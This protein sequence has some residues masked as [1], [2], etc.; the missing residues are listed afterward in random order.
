MKLKKNVEIS[1]GTQNLRVSIWDVQVAES[2]P[3]EEARIDPLIEELTKHHKMHNHTY[4]EIVL[5]VKGEANIVS[6]NDGISVKAPFLAF[7]PSGVPHV[8]INSYEHG[9]KRYLVNCFDDFFEKAGLSETEYTMLANENR[10][11]AIKLKEK[12]ADIFEAI[13][14]L[15]MKF[16]EDDA[17]LKEEMTAM[18]VRR[19]ARLK[20]RENLLRE[21]TDVNFGKHYFGS[22]LNYIA[23]NCSEKLSLSTLSSIFYVSRTKLAMDFNNIMG[24]SVGEYILKVRMDKA[25]IR[26]LKGDGISKTADICGFASK[27][28]FIQCFKRIVGVTPKQYCEAIKN[29]SETEKNENDF[30]KKSVSEVN[31]FP[32]KNKSE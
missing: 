18:F 6:M 9:Y 17:D 25:K 3:G 24:M 32:G 26:L 20:C 19:T 12:E 28:Y 15:I 23:E 2:K 10:V 29:Q 16:D 31:L 11:Y 13:F 22:L 5:V 27:S 14:N 21:S 7:Y 8:Q 1:D 30:S 4:N